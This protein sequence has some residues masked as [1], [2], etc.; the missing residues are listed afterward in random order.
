M[1]EELSKVRKGFE[2]YRVEKRENERMLKEQCDKLSDDLAKAKS[3]NFKLTNQV[4]YN[5]ERFKVY[6][7]NLETYRNTANVLE[8]RNKALSLDC[9][10][11][12]A[13]LEVIKVA[14]ILQYTEL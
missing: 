2:E 3:D 4:E 13:S 6:N 9:A 1:L 14:C 11:L 10:K 12:E 5:N 7:K 8:E